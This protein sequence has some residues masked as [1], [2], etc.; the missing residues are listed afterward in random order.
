[1][2]RN[3]ETAGYGPG[4]EDAVLKALSQAA[5]VHVIDTGDGTPGGLAVHKDWAV[6]DL[7]EQAE[8][9]LSTPRRR[10]GRSRLLSVEDA[11]A[12]TRR[13]CDAAE[14][15]IEVGAAGLSVTG[16]YHSATGGAGWCD[17]GA[18]VAFQGSAALLAW[19]KACA[20]W[21]TQEGF[22]E[23]I[24]DRLDDVGTADDL[25]PAQRGYAQLLAAGSVGTA[26]QLM[27]LARG[28]EL[29]MQT[30]VAARASS[31]AGALSYVWDETHA[32]IKAPVLYALRLPL[33]EGEAAQPVLAR[34]QYRVRDAK[35]FWRFRLQDL[36]ALIEARLAAIAAGVAEALAADGFAVVRVP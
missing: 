14:T 27:E 8:R 9:H 28:V 25:T 21:L 31:T 5:P 1:M 10:R 20:E 30:A 2:D 36:Q 19:Q 22:C 23:L 26:A 35:L 18:S 17:F 12:W 3:K 29:S 7:A 13:Y 6:I 32:P 24:A 16:N 34:L 15:L 33:F 4:Y 11:V